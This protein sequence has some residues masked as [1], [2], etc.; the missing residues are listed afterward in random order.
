MNDLVKMVSEKAGI[1]DTQAKVAVDYVVNYLK[2]KMP[3]DVGG[4]VDTLMKGG[5]GSASDL[6]GGLAD[7]V[8]GMFGK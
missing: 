1:S 6:A 7:K 2:D 3:A 4:Q 5:A 8:G